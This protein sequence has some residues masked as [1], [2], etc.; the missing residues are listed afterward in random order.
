MLMGTGG[1]I[2]WETAE[3]DLRE[4]HQFL[5]RCLCQGV[6]SEGWSQSGKPERGKFSG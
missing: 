2:E 4:N 6:G 3:L 1:P 5:P